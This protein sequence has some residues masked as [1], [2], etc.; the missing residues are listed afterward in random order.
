MMC[1]S[2]HSSAVLYYETRYRRNP[3][4]KTFIDEPAKCV[5]ISK[6]ILAWKKPKINKLAKL[7]IVRL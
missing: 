2:V 7:S 1:Y 6:W 4:K 5:V 3:H